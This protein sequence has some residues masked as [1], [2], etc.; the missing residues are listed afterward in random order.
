[1]NSSFPNHADLVLKLFDFNADIYLN[2]LII[3]LWNAIPHKFYSF[4]FQDKWHNQLHILI[5]KLILL[6]TIYSICAWNSFKW[7][8]LKYDLVNLHALAYLLKCLSIIKI[9]LN[10]N[11][12][13]FLFF[14]S[15]SLFILSLPTCASLVLHPKIVN[16][17]HR[18]SCDARWF[19]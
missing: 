10:W 19:E 12:F 13:R 5:N 8:R 15:M 1:M 3:P 2:N 9:K 18:G 14:H 11:S 6:W 7:I 17:Q 4:R 16:C